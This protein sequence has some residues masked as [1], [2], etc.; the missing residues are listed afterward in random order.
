[1]ELEAARATVKVKLERDAQL[2]VITES[3]VQ[4]A[5]AL[6]TALS[7]S[8]SQLTEVSESFQCPLDG[9][10]VFIVRPSVLLLR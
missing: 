5:A 4:E 3:K 9:G 8:L 2:R 10:Y 6:R 1:M 7:A